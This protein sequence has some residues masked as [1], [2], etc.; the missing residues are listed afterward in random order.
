MLPAGHIA[1]LV[2]QQAFH[3]GAIGEMKQLKQKS[4]AFEIILKQ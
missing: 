1:I 3:T 2:K 4:N